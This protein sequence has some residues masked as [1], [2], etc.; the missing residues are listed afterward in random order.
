MVITETGAVSMIDTV[1]SHTNNS[2]KN[3][4]TS[5]SSKQ[6]NSKP[7]PEDAETC[8]GDWVNAVTAQSLC[9]SLQMSVHKVWLPDNKSKEPVLYYV[10]T[11]SPNPTVPLA[12]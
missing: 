10:I 4:S 11:R 2:S 1:M 5:D 7:I 12:W 6:K 8:I 9:K 3:N